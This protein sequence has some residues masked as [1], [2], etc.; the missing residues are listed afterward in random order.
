MKKVIL[1][2]DSI[3]M[4]YDKYV[5]EALD[6]VAEVWYSSAMLFYLYSAERLKQ[7]GIS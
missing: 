3:R 2:G 6:G 1:I 5:K 4:G 7:K